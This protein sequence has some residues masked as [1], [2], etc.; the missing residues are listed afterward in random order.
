MRPAPSDDR[1]GDKRR[2]ERHLLANRA[3][4]HTRNPLPWRQT[5]TRASLS[6]QATRTPRRT[7]RR[8]APWRETTSRASLSRQPSETSHPKP[9][10]L[11]TNDQRS[12]TFSPTDD[13]GIRLSVHRR[14]SAQPARA[15]EIHPVIIDRKSR[16]L[17]GDPGRLGQGPF[18]SRRRGD[19]DDLATGVADEVMVVTGEILGEL[20]APVVVGTGNPPDGLGVDQGGD[21]SVGRALGDG[22]GGRQDLGNAQGPSGRGE[23]FDEGSPRRGVSLFDPGQADSHLWMQLSDLVVG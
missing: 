14:R 2:V 20:K 12:I 9:A 15:D 16:F 13:V 19:I 4:H 7:H 1:R 8:S 23:G 6:R 11:A 17:L 3:R 22:G 18:E 10:P 21:V 5:T